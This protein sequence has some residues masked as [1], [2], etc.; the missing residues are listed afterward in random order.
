M[1]A[2]CVVLLDGLG[3]RAYPE[4]GH[5][6]ANEAAHTPVLDALCEGGSCGLL[7]PLGPGRAPSSELAHWA[8]LGYHDDEFPGRAVLEALGHGVPLREDAVYAYAALRRG[9]R[10]DGGVVLTGRVREDGG[11]VP[12]QFVAE[13][14]SG[15]LSARCHYLGSGEAVLELTGGEADDRI[16]DTDPFFRERD[17]ML[18][19]LPLVPEAEASARAAANWTR[20]SLRE[21][22]D[23]TVVVATLKWWGRVRSAPSFPERHGLR[24]VVVGSSPFL[25]GLARA[26]GL[27]PRRVPDSDDPAHDLE[28]RL[29]VAAR[30]LE[31][32]AGF[33]WVH[34]KAVDEAGH[35]KSPSRRVTVL[36]RLDP[37]LAA[38]SRP[39]F[40][41]TVVCVTG[42]HATPCAPA[43]I[44]SGDPVPF[45][46]RGRGVR[47]DSVTCFGELD[48]AGGI[49]GRLRGEDVMPVL[50]NAAD[51]A[52]F[53][54]SRPT[55]VRAP[56]GHPERPEPFPW[57]AG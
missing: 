12:P 21:N 35:T 19:P 45:V 32:G 40:C 37:V 25:A 36:E 2:I 8:M 15:P 57:G 17:P 52:L 56:A 11:A 5:R 9:A 54:G 42:D 47:A 27:E 50:L 55:P 7:S 49:L 46:V 18:A 14:S 28:A 29:S 44:H 34:T 41:D 53:A 22:A 6:T 39:P 4:L 26:V 30:A 33:V 3:D 1:R 16:T 20:E 48:C 10:R 31:D 38:V 23:G 51:R 43:M 13:I 24:G